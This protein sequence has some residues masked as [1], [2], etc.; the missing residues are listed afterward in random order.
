MAGLYI[1]IP[2]CKQACSYC[3]F[4]F[5]TRLS[6]MDGMVDAIVKE[7]KMRVDYLPA[8]TLE[9]VY[10]GG[11]T[12]SLLNESQLNRIWNSI[13]EIFDIS[14]SAEVTL[15]ANP[16]D[17]TTSK[18]ESL[19]SSPINRLSIGIQSFRDID[20][21]FMRRA[22][23]SSQAHQCIEQAG[24][25]GF[26]NLSI[27]LI[28][29]TPGLEDDAWADN[30]AM[31]AQYKIPHLSCYA[32]TVE[33]KTLLAHQI[34][35]EKV[36]PPNE[37]RMTAQFD[38]LQSFARE[39]T[40]QH[41]EISNFARDGFLAV[42]NTNYWRQKPYLGI[43]PSAHS[44]DGLTRSWNVANNAQYQ[45]AIDEGVLPLT[46]EVLTPDQRYNEYVMTGLRT[47][48]GCDKG[49]LMKLGAPYLESFVK[50]ITP[51]VVRGWVA[52]QEDTFTLTPAGKL[53]ADHIASEL[54][55]V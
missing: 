50:V 43:G 40:Y 29:G 33:P 31:V 18:I 26:S 9:S 1:H 22:H 53:F 51:F 42:H 14:S 6:Q 45:K 15:E 35:K 25:A 47:Q 12:P 49:H 27:D 52:E 16:D 23:T 2:F 30:L 41:Y 10:W 24:K 17:L 19:R 38:M 7:L 28:Y 5:S 36:I 46:I 13:E 11:G 21:L 44:F 32:L 54:F 48:W 37:D 39:H 34:R 55:Q 3:N 4:H 20:L 8:P